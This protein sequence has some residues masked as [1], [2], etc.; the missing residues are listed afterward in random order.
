M[1]TIALILGLVSSATAFSALPANCNAHSKSVRPMTVE[2]LAPGLAIVRGALS[3]SEQRFVLRTTDELGARESNGFA[4]AGTPGR[5]RF[6]ERCA[7][8]P[9]KLSEFAIRS[10]QAASAIDPDMPACA[11][12]HVLINKYT[13]AAGLQWHRDIYTNDGD[14]DMPVILLSIGASC[15]FGVALPSAD[16]SKRCVVSLHSGDVLLFGGPSRFV[17]HAVLAVQLDTRPAWM[18]SPDSCRVSLTFR[19][20][21][22]VLGRE[23]R[24]RNFDLSNGVKEC[25]E[26]TQ[27]EWREGDPLAECSEC[28]EDER[29]LPEEASLY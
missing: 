13:T 3:E 24:F 10:S 16:K 19:E 23:N 27:R 28:N 11:P 8:M 14:A 15:R 18:A 22:S 6:Y 7:D 5:A 2:T 20:S 12:S 9:A 29:V 1:L 4:A 17:E 21:P 26:R 25:F